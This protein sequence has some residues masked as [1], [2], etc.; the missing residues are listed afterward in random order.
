MKV[1]ARS[2]L[3][4]DQ[5]GDMSAGGGLFGG[6]DGIFEV[7]DQRVGA[8]IPGACE[9]AFGIAGNEQERAQSH[10]AFRNAHGAR[11][12]ATDGVE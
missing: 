1:Q 12:G 8:A 4:L 7:E 5:T 6:R 3:V 2:A 11:K 10:V 9:L